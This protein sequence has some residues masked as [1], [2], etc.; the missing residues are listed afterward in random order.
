MSLQPDQI[1]QLRTSAGLNPTPPPVQPQAVSNVLAQRKAALNPVQAEPKPEAS[2]SDAGP[3]GMIKKI[4]N[5]VNNIGN[6]IK[7]SSAGVDSAIEGTGDYQG[8]S[9]VNRA[10]GATA[11]AFGAI[12]KVVGEFVPQGV[13]DAANKFL[14]IGTFVN[15]L[16]DLIGSTQAAQDFVT[17]HPDAAKNLEDVAKTTKSLGDISNDI[18]ATGGGTKVAPAVGKEA[19]AVASD[20]S[21]LAGKATQAVT[22]P[23]VDK[24]TQFAVDTEKKGW[25]KATTV[26]KASYNK[27][28]AIADNS[29]NVADTL[30]KNNLKLSDHVETNAAGNKVFNTADTAE[31]L[32]ADAAKLSNEM[33]RPALEKADASGAVP[34]TPVNDIIKSAMENINKSKMTAEAKDKMIESLNQTKISLTKQHPEGL[35]LTDLHDEKI[36]RDLNAKYSPVGD[37]ATNMEATKNKAIADATRKMVE[38]KAP[39]DVPVKAFNAELSKQHQ[40]ANY[41]DALHSK[42]VPKTILGSIAKTAAKVVGAGVGSGLGGGLMGTVGGYH[43]GGLIEGLVE[44]LPN[45]V[46]NSLLNNLKTTNPEAFTQVQNYLSN[47]DTKGSVA[48]PISSASKNSNIDKTI[49]PFNPKSQTVKGITK[50]AKIIKGTPNKQAGMIRIGGKAVKEVPDATKAEIV[51]AIDYLRLGKDVKKDMEFSVDKLAQ[52]FNINQDLSNTKIANLFQDLIEKTKTK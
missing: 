27:A 29:K 8:A 41:L 13:K 36:I 12:P 14:P 4:P 25:M 19:G 45:P 48:N 42:P 21:N 18:L 1:A 46:K 3:L 50:V 30:V 34:K 15:Q 35:S 17:N 10:V 5:L 38:E 49:Q 51:K 44:G 20:V 6:D 37:V 7:T 43:I 16:G 2:V 52:K 26:P 31:K 39:A 23:I 11:S 24:A 28:T 47:L 33:L 40:A 22:K 9:T 32:H